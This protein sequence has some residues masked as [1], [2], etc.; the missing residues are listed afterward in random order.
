MSKQSWMRRN[1]IGDTRIGP[2]HEGGGEEYRTRQHHT[3][4]EWESVSVIRDE[5]FTS[6]AHLLKKTEANIARFLHRNAQVINETA[7]P[8]NHIQDCRGTYYDGI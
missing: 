4:R 7:F 3:R 1:K 2:V 5:D 6:S 8:T